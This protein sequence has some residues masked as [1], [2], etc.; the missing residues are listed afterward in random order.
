MA[1]GAA[2]VEPRQ[3]GDIW[4]PVGEGHGVVDVV[5]M[6]AGDAEMLFDGRRRKWKR[7]RDQTGGTGANVSASPIR[8]STYGSRAWAQVEPAR[9]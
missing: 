3:T 7:V 4:D 1:A 9:S 6:T 5:D 2:G 8:C